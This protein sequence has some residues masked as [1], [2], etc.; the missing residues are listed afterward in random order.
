MA[1]HLEIFIKEAG[2]IVPNLREIFDL[3]YSY[4]NLRL[5]SQDSTD[6]LK[7]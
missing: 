6:V 2:R 3:P 5:I 1:F 7:H 4:Q